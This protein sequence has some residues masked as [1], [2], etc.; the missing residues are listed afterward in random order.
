VSRWAFAKRSSAS[1]CTS[2][3]GK[4]PALY[5]LNR[6]LPQCSSSASAMMLLAE[7]PVQEDVVGSLGHKPLLRAAAGRG[8]AGIRC[9]GCGPLGRLF[10]LRQRVAVAVDRGVAVGEEG[11]PRHALRVGDPLLVGF[12]V[13]AGGGP[14]LDDRPLG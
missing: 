8:A 7:L 13:A 1:G 10:Q 2:R 14:L 4:L 6:P 12:G 3:L 9:D 5:A 11:F